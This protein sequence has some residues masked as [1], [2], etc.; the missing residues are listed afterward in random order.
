[1][2][3]TWHAISAEEAARVLKSGPSGLAEAEA[4]ERLRQC[5]PNLV[6]PRRGEGW[7]VILLRQIKSPIVY[8][9]LG[10]AALGAIVGKLTDSLMVL[11]VVVLNSLIGFVQEYRAGKAIAALSRLLPEQATVVRAG[12]QTEIPVQHLVPG[13]I[14]LLESGDKVPADV[15]LID[16]SSF[17]AE[18]AA[19]TGESLPA[20]KHEDPVATDAALGD[21]SSMAF[22]GTLVVAGTA[23]AIVVA[24]GSATELGRI[25]AMLSESEPPR[26]PLARRLDKL[27]RIITYCVLAVAAA[28]VVVGVLREYSLV[29]SA[30]A[31][32]TLAVALVPEGLPALVTI[33]SAIGVRAMAKR[34]VLIRRLPAVE[35]LGRTTV[36]C[37][38]KTGT[39][40]RNEMTVQALWTCEGE[41]RLSGIGYV[42]EGALTRNG[43]GVHPIPPV[44]QELLTAGSLCNDAT[45]VHQ[46]GRWAISG[47]PTEGAIVV[48][49]RKIG[50][51]E[52]A[53]REQWPRA[54]VL[55]FDSKNKYMATLHTVDSATVLICMKGAPEVVT[56][57]CATLSD[58]SPMDLRRVHEAAERLATRGMRVLAVASDSP[59]GDATGQ[60]EPE[61]LACSF[62]LLGL[63]GMIDPPRREAAEAV[64]ACH[65]AGI[66]VKMVT[67]DHPATAA[68]IARQL[69][70]LGPDPDALV[71][72]G[73]ELAG[74]EDEALSTLAKRS[75][76]FARVAPEHKLRLVKALQ[77][78]GEIVAM[79]GDGVNDAPALK[80][81]DIGIAM[82]ITGTAAAREAS[83][84]VLADDNFASI[85]AAVEEGR[86][87][88]DNLVKSLA[89]ILPT[90]LGQSM[91]LL[92]A[93]L[94]FPVRDGHLL[95]P[96]E[97]VQIL[98][99]NLVVAIALALPLAFESKEPD[100]MQRP[101]RAPDAPLLDR[102][103]VLRTFLVGALM[104]ACAVALFFYE[105]LPD[106]D[107]GID[108][109]VAQAESQTM[110]VTTII[111]FQAVYLLNC[112]S[113]VD[114]IR[115]IGL[116]S[117]RYVYGGIAVTLALQLCLVYMPALNR[118]FHTHPLDAEDWLLPLAVGLVCL[119]VVS[120]EKL[121]WKHKLR[122][123]KNRQAHGSIREQ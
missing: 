43:S 48:A 32:V 28:I 123:K 98:W 9:L 95:M 74:A 30:F 69:G 4:Q 65:E 26:T 47:D 70:L 66:T 116:F 68:A 33:A 78:N 117:N 81:A 93:V 82:G 83:D 87:V 20:A 110:V 105:Y 108:P 63:A 54:D 86:R 62:R 14:V 21:R 80:R 11:A 42:P 73:A 121:W 19:L 76:V 88:Y 122:P 44:V 72:S 10:A 64:R 59:A 38:D 103:L 92:V 34:Q 101:P 112:R 2:T 61:K 22:G 96:I 120:V 39:L 5:G 15:R 7:P 56:G 40:T 57:F 13:D 12:R 114:S 100:V 115:R 109:A 49:T 24:T 36:I 77:A 107:R 119:P 60:L 113:L 1:M 45:L 8:V 85:A 111:I 102:F 17:A 79:T 23:R 67:G 94:F 84:M 35:T 27:A 41:Y 53:L 18:E 118:L 3:Q 52:Y 71:L 55:P 16:T 6:D 89:F 99:V 106:L 75:N 51:D 104:T 46:E 90:G 97:P 25:S 91:L 50:L 58:G 29:D 31:A 37:T